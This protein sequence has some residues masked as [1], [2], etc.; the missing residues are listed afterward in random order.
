MLHYLAGK[1]IYVSSGSACSTHHPGISG[2]LKGIGLPEELLDA[3]IRVSLCEENTMQDAEL[4]LTAM[5]E[6]VPML[7]KYTRR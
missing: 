2:T 3:T 1:G 7:R 5:R 6:L 4:F